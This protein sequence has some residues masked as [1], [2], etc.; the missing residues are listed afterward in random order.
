MIEDIHIHVLVDPQNDF[1]NA[2]APL[3]SES[4]QTIIVPRIMNYISNHTSYTDYFVVTKDTHFT[5]TYKESIE[6]KNL[7]IPHAEMFSYGWKMNDA[8]LKTFQESSKFKPAF[9][10]NTKTTYGSLTLPDICREMMPEVPPAD[11]TV[12]GF[13]LE[14][15][16]FAN[17]VILRCANENIPVIVDASLCGYTD[18]D[19]AVCAIKMLRN[20]DIQVINSEEKFGV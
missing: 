12:F 5:D 15:C 3:G 13:D 10:V 6:G 2:D 4:N 17:A 11:I 9:E 14:Y 19:K 1:I 18:K 8:I 7:P 20:L 16:V